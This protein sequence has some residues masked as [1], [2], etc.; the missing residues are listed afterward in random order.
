MNFKYLDTCFSGG[1]KGIDSFNKH[2]K[3]VSLACDDAF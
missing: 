3:F 1:F 2:L